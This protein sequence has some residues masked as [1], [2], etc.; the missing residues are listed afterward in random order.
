[1]HFCLMFFLVGP[2]TLGIYTI[3]WFH[4]LSARLGNELARRGIGY[5]FGASDYWLWNVLG[6]LILIGPFVY[7]YKLAKASNLLAQHYNLY[8]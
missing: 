5:S 1:M 3:I 7:I 6:A 2:I 8:G 4:K